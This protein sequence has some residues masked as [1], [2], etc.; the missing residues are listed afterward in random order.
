MERCVTQA[1][2]TFVDVQPMQT[3]KLRDQIG[4]SLR[5]M[6][7]APADLATPISMRELLSAIQRAEHEQIIRKQADALAAAARPKLKRQ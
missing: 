3:K 6:A 1:A 7:P 5:A 4:V 2:S